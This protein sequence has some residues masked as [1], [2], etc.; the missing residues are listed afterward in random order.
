M[1]RGG[2]G[3]S[4]ARSLIELVESAAIEIPRVVDIGELR[5]LWAP[6]WELD[7]FGN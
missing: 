1:S 7:E 2:G 5:R 3:G 4:C 6:G